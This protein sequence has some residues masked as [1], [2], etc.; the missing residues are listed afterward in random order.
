MDTIW[1]TDLPKSKGPKY[2]RVADTI[3]K[4]IENKQLEVGVKL[5]PVR[6]LAYRLQ[7]TPGTV[8]RAYSI[9]TEEGLPLPFWVWLCGNPDTLECIIITFTVIEKGE[10]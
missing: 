10:L 5:P 6:E 3:R 2:T 4:A 8:A 1:P 7:I 9:L